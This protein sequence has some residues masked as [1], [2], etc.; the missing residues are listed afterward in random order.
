MSRIPGYFSAETGRTWCTSGGVSGR[1]AVFVGKLSESRV[2]EA[3][4]GAARAP[5][6]YIS[7]EIKSPRK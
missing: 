5:S 7:Q 4:V 2:D 1:V 6:R 3:G